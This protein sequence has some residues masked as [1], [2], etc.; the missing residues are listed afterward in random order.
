M[1][2][3]VFPLTALEG[4]RLEVTRRFPDESEL[5]SLPADNW[6][7]FMAEYSADTR[8][9]IRAPVD[10]SIQFV[11]KALIGRPVT[12]LAFRPANFA[13]FHTIPG[14]AA[15]VAKAFLFQFSELDDEPTRVNIYSEALRQYRRRHGNRLIQGSFSGGTLQRFEDW[16]LT[17]SDIEERARNAL[18]LGASVH[19]DRGQA[20]AVAGVGLRVS[21]GMVYYEGSDFTAAPPYWMDF[22]EYFA[23]HKAYAPHEELGFPFDD[24]PSSDLFRIR[25]ERSDN[26]RADGDNAFESLSGGLQGVKIFHPPT[27]TI[28]QSGSFVARTRQVPGELFSFTPNARVKLRFSNGA[29]DYRFRLFNDNEATTPVHSSRDLTGQEP[30]TLFGNVGYAWPER[31]VQPYQ[32]AYVAANGVGLSFPIVRDL[33]R[34]VDEAASEV[35]GHKAR[36]AE[37]LQIPG[38]AERTTLVDTINRITRA[39]PADLQPRLRSAIDNDRF[40][41]FSAHYHQHILD[42]EQAVEKLVAAMND[43]FFEQ[44]RDDFSDDALVIFDK[45]V[46]AL[47]NEERGDRFLEQTFRGFLFETAE[48]ADAARPLSFELWKAVWNSQR[49]VRSALV[50]LLFESVKEDMFYHLRLAGMRLGTPLEHSIDPLLRTMRDQFTTRFGELFAIN[51]QDEVPMV[52]FIENPL[53]GEVSS[54]RY[55]YASP[56]RIVFEYDSDAIRQLDFSRDSGTSTGTASRD[57]LART[58]NVFNLLGSI[59][60]LIYDGVHAWKEGD[61]EAYYNIAKDIIGIADDVS[62]LMPTRHYAGVASRPG[63]AAI[64]GGLAFVSNAISL[65]SMI[66]GAWSRH[67]DGDYRSA[68]FMALAAST[69]SV[70]LGAE[71]LALLGAGAATS[72][73]LAFFIIGGT[74]LSVGFNFLAQALARPE[75][76]IDFRHT[77]FGVD[78]AGLET[79]YNRLAP[80]IQNDPVQLFRRNRRFAWVGNVP[81]Q[82]AHLNRYVEPV[83]ATLSNETHQDP[84]SGRE[85][86]VIYIDITGARCERYSRVYFELYSQGAVHFGTAGTFVIDPDAPR[87]GGWH[88]VEPAFAYRVTLLPRG[89]ANISIRMYSEP[90]GPL[91]NV[92]RAVVGVTFQRAVEYVDPADPLTEFLRNSPFSV[93]LHGLIFERT[94]AKFMTF[95]EVR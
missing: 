53:T 84:A 15:P 71:A 43:D 13:A 51:V 40:T 35:I 76:E 57:L 11:Q 19:V 3:V 44:L 86:K 83:S 45:A 82:I 25:Y 78:Y 68:G 62:N 6:S 95:L 92:N 37:F 66:D 94:A 9:A 18:T 8:I 79:E 72:G 31:R 47:R 80:D 49:R 27:E 54:V 75:A 48:T 21:V 61:Q 46:E 26:P 58:L 7:S 50:K 90:N 30:E 17:E 88:P 59:F 63:W 24:P 10:G 56:T 5:V 89:R 60:H 2:R 14:W 65:S 42:K 64:G 41:P 33:I 32:M 52:R 16:M 28:E 69:A 74:L 77:Y 12:L 87:R 4:G 1:S 55:T 34:V 73:P 85:M 20:F 70:S 67:A 81:R 38:F 22:H 23:R 36:L 93:A 91:A 29:V 39:A